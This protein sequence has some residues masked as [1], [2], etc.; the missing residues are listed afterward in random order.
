MSDITMD[1]PTCGAVQVTVERKEGILVG[2]CGCMLTELQVRTRTG[3]SR[4]EVA[5][6]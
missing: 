3:A 4:R 6:I 2:G 5:E 1:C